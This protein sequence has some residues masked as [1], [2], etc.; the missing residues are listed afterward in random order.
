M[1][2]WCIF[3]LAWAVPAVRK[4][5]TVTNSDGTV[6]TL[7]L[8]GDE[9]FH[10]YATL[11]GIPVVQEENGDYRLAPERADS[12][13]TEWRRRSRS[14]HAMRTHKA[15][16]VKARRALGYP[17]SYTG[18]R[19]G[20]VI[21]VNFSN[22]S[23]ASTHTQ[24]EFEDM[25]NMKGYK[26]NHHYGSVHDY[27]YDQSYGTF[28]L[29]FDVYGPVTVSQ[30]YS[31]YGKNT[32]TG[33]D[34]YV[35]TLA[36]EACKLADQMYDV[37]WADYDWDNDGEVEQVCI[38]YAGYGENA[39]APASTIWP[40]EWT[41]SEGKWFGDG[42]GSI[43]LGGRVIDTYAM[44]CELAGASGTT[45]CG[46]GSVCHEISHC[47]GLPDFYDTSY[48][49]GFGMNAW[50]LMD[51][52]CYNGAYHNS[53]CPVGYT[54]YERWFAGWLEMEELDGPV[55]VKDMPCIGD[56]PVAYA[57]YNDG[58]RNEFFILENRQNEG[59]FQYME[60]YTDVHGM[61]MC[62]VDY[63]EEAWINNMPNNIATHQ[64][65]SIVPAGGEYG[66]LVG[67]SGS[68]YY[69]VSLAQY[70]SQVFPGGKNVTAFTNDSHLAVGGKLFHANT[71]GTRLLSKP[72][73]DI[74]EKDG[75]ISFKVMGGGE[76]S[77]LERLELDAIDGSATMDAEFFTLG[78]TRVHAPTEHGIYIVR[79][80]GT[81][82]KVAF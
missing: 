20:I 25:F 41:L 53:E 77:S 45:L 69:S 40:H 61:L 6:L 7:V 70:Q 43:T 3:M 27:F 71:D 44:S 35:A 38:I 32:P 82:R 65:M 68:K 21:L 5:F 49:G 62:H 66:T 29:T 73:T 22:K 16:E 50:S 1:L 58:N 14:R 30:P 63:D 76:S 46:I 72:I 57:I 55:T 56:E 79:E 15:K 23:M 74:T 31:F 36:A 10:Y 48:R 51:G 34:S 59:W 17:S 54:A 47:F 24:R 9:T 4:P 80:R 11:E 12:I 64:R 28:N 19:K 33:D 8:C 67:A 60:R 81:T 26:R 13:G 2:A 42:E 75:R 18:D 52:G 78:G 37:N 39:G